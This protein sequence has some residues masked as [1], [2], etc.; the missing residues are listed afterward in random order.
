MILQKA[1]AVQEVEERS[2]GILPAVARAFHAL[3]RE[4]FAP[5]ANSGQGARAP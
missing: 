4:H 2:A 5:A 1:T 3:W